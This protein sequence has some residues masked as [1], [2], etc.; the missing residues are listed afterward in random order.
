MTRLPDVQHPDMQLVHHQD[1]VC[2]LND[3]APFRTGGCACGNIRYECTE[4]PIVQLI[5]HCRDC[6]RASGSAFAPAMFF[7]SDKFR[8]LKSTPKFHEVVGGSGRKIQRGFCA[9]CGSFICA[10]WPA[11]PLIMIVSPISLDD[12]SGFEPTT[13]IWI[14]RAA[15]WHP[16]HPTTSKFD[17]APLNGVNDKIDAYFANR[18][19]SK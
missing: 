10:H 7:A 17:G 2:R 6:Q 3:T 15:P 8:F 4:E 11:N 5:C 12:R 16:V 13:E 1:P 9:E 19:A 14:E 18:E